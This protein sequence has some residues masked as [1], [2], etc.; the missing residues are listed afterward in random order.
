MINPYQAPQAE[1]PD[2]Q[3]VSTDLSS[4]VSAE[5]QLSGQQIRTAVNRFLL[6][7]CGIRLTI[8][9]LLMISLSIYV[10]GYVGEQFG[11][12][13]AYNGISPSLAAAMFGSQLLVMLLATA[14][15]QSLIW[16]I[17]KQISHQLQTVGVVA[18][19]NIEVSIQND[20]LV[21]NGPAGI[22]TFPIDQMA[23]Q[24]SS[25][26]LLAIVSRDQFL[27]IPRWRELRGG[28]PCSVLTKELLSFSS[29]ERID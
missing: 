6:Y 4:H 27:L 26:G 21:W 15:Y 7:R 2:D 5:F 24:R 22:H 1:N 25:A 9:S 16:R 28:D 20:R 10:A 3:G 13:S 17:R 11:I 18:N 29:V 14:V 19:A 23:F 12:L 8:A